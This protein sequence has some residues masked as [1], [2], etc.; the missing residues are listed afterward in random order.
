MSCKVLGEQARHDIQPPPGAR[1]TTIVTLF[2]LWN[3]CAFAASVIERALIVKNAASSA[4]HILDGHFSLPDSADLG[5][6]R[7]V[8]EI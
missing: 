1:P 7:F 4:R 8:I 3:S 6:H 5:L 2:P